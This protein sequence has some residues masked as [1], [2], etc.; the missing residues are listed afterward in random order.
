MISAAAFK[1]FGP[2]ELN[3][4]KKFKIEGHFENCI[5]ITIPNLV[6]GNRGIR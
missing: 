5:T 6:G 3:A 4:V 2:Y 1:K